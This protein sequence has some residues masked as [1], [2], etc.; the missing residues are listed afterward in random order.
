MPCRWMR[1]VRGF[2]ARGI[3]GSSVRLLLPAHYA[4]HS[5]RSRATAGLALA[6]QSMARVAGPAPSPW[7]NSR[8]S[9]LAHQHAP[10]GLPKGR[11]PAQGPDARRH[12]PPPHAH[13]QERS[14]CHHW[15]PQ[16]APPAGVGTSSLTG[17]RT[18]PSPGRGRQSSIP[19]PHGRRPARRSRSVSNGKAPATPRR[20]P[21]P[22]G[23]RRSFEV[24]QER[25]SSQNSGIGGTSA[26]GRRLIRL[27]G[28]QAAG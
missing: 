17:I 25:C 10:P 9:L 4:A 15:L 14:G 12:A 19:S 23:G 21:T 13:G 11:R 20:L 6:R 2:T 8:R 16:G 5:G 28:N 1:S 7:L 18:A 24:Q 22:L 26:A 3:V 27:S